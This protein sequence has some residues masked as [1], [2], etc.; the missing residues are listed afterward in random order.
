MKQLQQQTLS[1]GQQREPLRVFRNRETFHTHHLLF[2]ELVFSNSL[3]P[4]IHILACIC[5]TSWNNTAIPPLMRKAGK[6]IPYLYICKKYR[7][8]SIMCLL[9][10]SDYWCVCKVLKKLKHFKV[11]FFLLFGF[12]VLG[13][14]KGGKER[15]ANQ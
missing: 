12:D 6:T 13:F 8:P 10:R 2:L 9:K 11:G 5:D 15:G 14:S 7:K 4:H 3:K 1:S